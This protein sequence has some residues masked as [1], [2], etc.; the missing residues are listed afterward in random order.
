MTGTKM[1]LDLKP[2]DL[3]FS[4]RLAGVWLIWGA[5]CSVCGWMLSALHLLNGW[6]HLLASPGLFV[7]CWLWWRATRPH[8]PVRTWWHRRAWMFH[9]LPL[10][11]AAT[12]C[13]SLIGAVSYTPWSFD[14]ASYRLPRLLDWWTANHWYWIGTVD[15]RLDFSSCGFEWQMLPLLELTRSDR[16]LFLL[17]WL[18]CLLAPGLI[19]SVFCSLGVNPR[20]ARRWMWLLPMGYCYALQCGGL[21]NDGY[22]V[23]FTLAAVGFAVAGCRSGR[24]GLVLMSVLAAGLLTGA[25]L[26]N[27]PLLL[28]LGLFLLPAFPHVNVRCWITAGTV[29]AAVL[30]SFLPLAFLCWKMTGDWTGDPNDQWNVHP[31]G[32]LGWLIPNALAFLND[33]TQPPLFA[34]ILSPAR[35]YSVL[36]HVLSPVLPWLPQVPSGRGAMSFSMAYEGN[37]GLGFGVGAYMIL[38]LLGAGFVKP[39]Q[40]RAAPSGRLPM[41]WRLA[42]LSAW[43][44]YMVMLMKLG[45]GHASRIGA[46]FYP[47][48]L[49]SLLRLRRVGWLERRRFTEWLAVA[50]ALTV[51]P[52]IVLT[53]AR[54]LLPSPVVSWLASKPSLSFLAERYC[55]WT[56]L[57]DPL[58]RL[59]A[60]IPPE[61]TKLGYAGGF[62]ETP[63]GLWKPIGSRQVVELGLPVGSKAG[64]PSDL[65]Y[66]VVTEAGLQARYGADLE[67]WCRATRAQVIFQLQ[68]NEA[69]T[70][71]DLPDLSFWTLV[72]FNR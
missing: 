43:P 6:G 9:P 15:H 23:N 27:A 20:T 5:W 31:H 36:R 35:L 29:L 33:A 41:I 52:I 67:T 65:Q 44:A 21:Q 50:A 64:P 7:T 69:L 66:A 45:G 58:W 55:H 54:P 56:D 60:L 26:S 32:A 57:R 8:A 4:L 11:Y 10:I 37:S 71:H 39:P 34:G 2:T 16:A 28:P 19:F 49:V 59:R 68:V 62:K 17:N 53:P 47:L 22:A 30:G 46:P 63:Y 25:K 61:A 70:G 1:N 18:P 40:P 51:V 38:V 72:K 3:R 14:S 13:L 12:V 48:L 24:S 42:L